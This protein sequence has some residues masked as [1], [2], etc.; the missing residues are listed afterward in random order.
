MDL[1]NELV[2][3]FNFG[4]RRGSDIAARLGPTFDSGY[5]RGVILQA[6]IEFETLAREEPVFWPEVLH[7]V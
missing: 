4:F 2:Y 3:F 1:K 6:V 7:L 5:T